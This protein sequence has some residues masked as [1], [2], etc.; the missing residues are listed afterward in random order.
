[1]KAWGEAKGARSL[2][3]P[4]QTL[5]GASRPQHPHLTSVGVVVTGWSNF[6]HVAAFLHSEGPTEVRWKLHSLL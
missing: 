5:T 2:G 6:L 4:P 1:M 3:F